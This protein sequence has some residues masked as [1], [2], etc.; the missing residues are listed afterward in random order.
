M[1]AISKLRAGWQWCAA[2]ELWSRRRTAGEAVPAMVLGLL[3]A[4]TE[5]LL[6]GGELR[7]WMVPPMVVVLS[8][9]RRRL[10]VSSWC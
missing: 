9:L 2:P 4:G 10:P 8:L 1:Y 3:A 5:E 7:L 6:R